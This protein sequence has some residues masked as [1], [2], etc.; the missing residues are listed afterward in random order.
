[1]GR[2]L[3]EK[4]TEEINTQEKF[5]IEADSSIK[6]ESE[7]YCQTFNQYQPIIDFNNGGFSS[8]QKFPM[9]VGWE[10]L[11]QYYYLTHEEKALNRITKIYVCQNKTCKFPVD[12]VQ[13]ALSLMRMSKK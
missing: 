1:M 13:K 9:P 3:A 4:L 12:D 2:F 10:F 6:L 11:L 7:L 8:S 5:S